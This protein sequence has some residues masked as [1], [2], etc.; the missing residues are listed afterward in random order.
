LGGFDGTLGF[1]NQEPNVKAVTHR[2]IRFN[3][4][5]VSVVRA[6][7]VFTSSA[8]HG[9]GSKVLQALQLQAL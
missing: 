2:S 1:V 8:G 5:E 7:I 3:S 6:N 9:Y 4:I